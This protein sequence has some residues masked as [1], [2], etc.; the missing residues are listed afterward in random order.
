MRISGKAA[1]FLPGRSRLITILQCFLIPVVCRSLV[2]L[3]AI[4]VFIHNGEVVQFRI[5]LPKSEIMP[6]MRVKAL[7]R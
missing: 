7:Q 2:L 6:F 4:T 5:A 3:D 1:F